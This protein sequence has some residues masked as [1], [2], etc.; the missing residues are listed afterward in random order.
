[1]GFSGVWSVVVANAVEPRSG[2]PI[3]A[4]VEALGDQW[5]FLVLRD[6]IF[7]DRRYFRELLTGSTEGIASN[8]LADRLKRFVAAGILTRD[9]AVRGQ[10]ARYSLTEAGIETLPIIYA[11]GNWGLDWRPGSPELRTRQELMRAEGPDFVEEFMSEL[12]VRHL[13][14]TPVP[15]DGPGPLARLDAAYAA[16]RPSTPADAIDAEPRVR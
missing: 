16:A 8:I 7:G 9:D 5:S 12:R 14:M 13:G 11:L 2:C 6:I 15:K 10:R 3:N 4:A 1:M